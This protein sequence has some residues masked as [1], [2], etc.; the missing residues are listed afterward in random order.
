MRKV[1][2]ISGGQT[3]ADRAGLE[4]ALS[5]G[6]PIDGL[7]PRGRKAE[8]G[9]VP[10][11]YTLREIE[12]ESYSERTRMNVNISDA[13]LIYSKSPMTGGTKM[14]SDFAH[15][16]FKPV[17]LTKPVGEL[18]RFRD[19]LSRF[20]GAELRIMVAGPREAKDPGI[21][22]RSLPTFYLFLKETTT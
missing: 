3:G 4:A 5:L 17:F 2:V 15:E 16:Q 7:I 14:T 11:R 20:E 8:D 12:S 21:Y 13:V 18:E 10:M 1:T 9:K 22:A 6:L 19:W